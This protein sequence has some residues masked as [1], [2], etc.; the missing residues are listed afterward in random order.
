MIQISVKLPES[1]SKTIA[2]TDYTVMMTKDG[3]VTFNGKTARLRD[4]ESL[5]QQANT[6]ASNKENATVAIVA[7]V[8]VP[9]K[10]VSDIMEIAS[11]LKMRAIIATQPKK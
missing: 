7:E 8:G 9:W 1:T 3:S 4:I 10:R 2:P 6:E 5:I 11:R